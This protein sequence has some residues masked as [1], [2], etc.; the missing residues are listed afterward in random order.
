[1]V[2]K[3]V[4]RLG[5]PT[6]HGGTVVSASSNFRMFGK[7]VACLG[8]KVTCPRQGHGSCTIVEGDPT[9]TIDGRHVAL[10]GHKIS[11]GASLIST[12]PNVTRSHE[13]IGAAGARSAASS[14]NRGAIAKA[15][16]VLESDNHD[17]DMHWL[18]MDKD[19]G[20][21][22]ANLPY[23]ITLQDGRS[24]EGMTDSQGLTNKIGD[25]SASVATIEVPYYG[26]SNSNPDPCEQ[27]DTCDC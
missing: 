23:K 2:G 10:E 8:D 21:P 18:I 3:H 1:M 7:Q 11:C 26:D 24:I 9:W 16:L 22:G 20:E 15:A 12:L 19:T 25:V 6:T 13:D 5:D 17:Y 14:A 4:I 27:Y